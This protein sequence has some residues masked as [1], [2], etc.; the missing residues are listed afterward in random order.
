MKLRT[1]DHGNRPTVLLDAMVSEYCEL[2]T[3][4]V[5]DFRAIYITGLQLNP[6]DFATLK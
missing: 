6:C 3:G 2:T 5:Q 4:I 1:L